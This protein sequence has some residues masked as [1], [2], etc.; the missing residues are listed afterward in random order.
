MSE[1]GFSS[2]EVRKWFQQE[3]S[4]L[5]PAALGSMSL[6]RS[7]CV[8]ERCTACESGEQHRSF[9]LYTRVHGRRHAVYVPKELVSELEAA[10]ERGR[11]LEARLHEA[12]VRYA[13]ALKLERKRHRRGKG[14]E[15]S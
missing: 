2:S 3:V 4:E 1:R 15:P 10:L 14:G 11:K 9:V 12:A 5:W 6:R 7:P 13:K 8:R